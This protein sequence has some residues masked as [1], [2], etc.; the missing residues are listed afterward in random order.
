VNNYL[1][2]FFNHNN[3][4][5]D[6]QTK[7]GSTLFSKLPFI[8]PFS[9]ATQCRIKVVKKKYCKD[10]DIRLVF[11]SYKLKNV[12][13]VKDSVPKSLRYLQVWFTNFHAQAVLPIMSVRLPDIFPLGLGASI[14]K[15]QLPYV[16]TFEGFRVLQGSPFGLACFSI[17]DLA[18]AVFQLRTKEALHIEWE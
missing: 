18:P 9:C 5:Q 13:G 17:L 1:C 3:F 14:F 16:Q 11:T 4:P 6:E 10:L 15:P 8:S 7:K 2:K 12:F